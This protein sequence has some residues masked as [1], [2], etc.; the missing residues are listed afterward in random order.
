MK[1]FNDYLN[2][3]AIVDE[4]MG[5]RRVHA[6]RLQLQDERK[7]MTLSEYAEAATKD[8]EALFAEHGLAVPWA[9]LEP[10]NRA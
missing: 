5:V 9:H 4:P 2:D 1:T 3:P 8:T 7:N 6:I 10:C